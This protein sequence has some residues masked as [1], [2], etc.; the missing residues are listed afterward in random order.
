MS[1]NSSIFIL[2]FFFNTRLVVNFKLRILW[3]ENTK[4]IARKSY[5]ATAF[6]FIYSHPFSDYNLCLL[7][8]VRNISYLYYRFAKDLSLTIEILS[9]PITYPHKDIPFVSF[10]NYGPPFQCFSN[11]IN[12]EKTYMRFW[13]SHSIQI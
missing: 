1:I 12:L 9:T 5:G 10:R 7:P 4:E 13:F 3:E 8:H 11:E 2:L 6:T